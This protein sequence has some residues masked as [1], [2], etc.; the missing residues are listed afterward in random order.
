M[1]RAWNLTEDYYSEAFYNSVTENPNMV[2]G[3]WPNLEDAFEGCWRYRGTHLIGNQFLKIN[4]SI[5]SLGPCFHKF[6]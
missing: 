2:S 4:D 5:L 1:I 3:P 6:F